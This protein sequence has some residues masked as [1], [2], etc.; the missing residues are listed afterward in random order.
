MIQGYGITSLGELPSSNSCQWNALPAS[1]FSAAPASLAILTLIIDGVS[2]LFSQPK[3]LDQLC[4]LCPPY[5]GPPLFRIPGRGEL[6]GKE[7]NAPIESMDRRPRR[8]FQMASHFP[9]PS[10]LPIPPFS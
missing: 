2:M 7:E 1:V 3:L 9:R 6:W 5:L 10:F 8:S 4:S